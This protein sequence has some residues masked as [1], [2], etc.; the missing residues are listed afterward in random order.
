MAKVQVTVRLEKEQ[1]ARAMKAL[2]AETLTEAIERALAFAAEKATH[3]AIIRKYSG[4]GGKNA[5]TG[6]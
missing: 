4:V 5:C 2:G 3:D 1:L 6:G